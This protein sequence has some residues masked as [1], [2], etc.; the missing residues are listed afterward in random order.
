[1]GCRLWGHT[2][3]DRT[4]VMQQQQQSNINAV[5]KERRLREGD[6]TKEAEA[7]IIQIWR[8]QAKK[9]RQSIEARK[10]KDTDSSLEPQEETQTADI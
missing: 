7:G 5:S 3:S 6:V 8:G 9:C 10:V 1:M 2:E 4:K